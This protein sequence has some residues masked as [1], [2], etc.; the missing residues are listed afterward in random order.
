MKQ[1]GIL[2]RMGYVSI[3]IVIVA[4]LILSGGAIALGSFSDASIQYTQKALT[5][6]GNTGILGDLENSGDEMSYDT[7]GYEISLNVS[8]GDI[9]PVSDFRLIK[10]ATNDG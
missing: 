5:I 2:N 3:E 4:A 10:N 9:N 6:L 8:V 1:K 7:Y